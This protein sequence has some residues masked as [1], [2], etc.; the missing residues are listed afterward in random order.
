ME[1]KIS[2]NSAI[3]DDGKRLGVFSLREVEPNVINYN[4]AITRVNRFKTSTSSG[5]A[6]RSLRPLMTIEP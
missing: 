2:Y 5:S 3:A 4:S 1:N 6:P